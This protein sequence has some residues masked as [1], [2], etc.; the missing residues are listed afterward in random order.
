MAYNVQGFRGGARD[1]AVAV[2]AESPDV[3][4]LNE[5][6]YLGFRLRRF[7]R[8]LGMERAAGT[9][10]IR[11]VPNAVLARPPWRVIRHEVVVL[12]RVRR[13]LRRGVVTAVIG[14]AGTRIAVAAVHLGLSEGERA[15]HARVLTDLLA[16]RQER[17]ILGGDL[18][19]GPD[20][21]AAT[22]IAERYW[23][24]FARAGQGPGH[25]FPSVEPHARIDYLF[26]SD[27]LTAERAWVG[28]DGFVGIS[29]HRPVLA[30]LLF[31]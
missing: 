29:D 4:L 19:E 8:R 12:P 18:N 23:D 21:R 2:E 10:L 3:L 31:D 15:E 17:A 22:W 20:G 27:G 5:T 7:A 24:A 11:P 30:D 13:T 16:G 28:G 1:M 14:R 26:I 25:T 9:R 6:R